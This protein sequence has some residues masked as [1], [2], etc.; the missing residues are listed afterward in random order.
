M[1]HDSPASERTQGSEETGA[2]RRL[3]GEVKLVLLAGDRR[4]GKERRQEL[5]G[6]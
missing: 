2:Q 1:G 5:S 4:M 6:C 3:C